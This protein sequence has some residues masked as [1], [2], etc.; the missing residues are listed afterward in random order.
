MSHLVGGDGQWK[1]HKRCWDFVYIW[2]A[3]TVCALPFG[4][5]FYKLGT[6]TASD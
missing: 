1:A 3:N 2:I 6:E 4:V 5:S